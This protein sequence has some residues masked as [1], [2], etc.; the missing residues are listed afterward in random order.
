MYWNYLLIVVA[1]CAVGAAVGFKRLLWFI[2]VGYGLGIFTGALA[3]LGIGIGAGNLHWVFLLQSALFLIYGLRLGLFLLFRETRNAAYRKYIGADKKDGKKI[4][5][6]VSFFMWV[7]CAFFY[8]GE[9]S[10]VFF[11]MMQ[12]DYDS[13]VLPLVGVCI[14]ALGLV[15]EAV[16]DRQKSAQKAEN[17]KMVATKGL[18]RYVRCANYLGEILMWTGVFVGGLDT[19]STAGQWIYAV[20]SYVM[21][22][23]I[24]VDGAKR[25]EARQTKSYGALPEY[26]EYMNRTPILFPFLPLYHLNRFDENGMPVEKAKKK[27]E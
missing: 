26:R 16:A 7:Y 12:N 17:P 13:I 4:P 2:T 8:A 15:I 19:F 27:A 3:N 10:P 24:M 11:R 25:T 22:V 21:I 23:L 6:F 1:A 5:F 18:Y 20:I 14:S 9:I